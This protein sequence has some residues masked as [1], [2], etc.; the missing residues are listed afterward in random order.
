MRMVLVRLAL[1]FLLLV[2]MTRLSNAQGVSFPELD[3]SV[4]GLEGITYL[5][6]VRQ[7]IP[8]LALNGSA[9]QGHDLIDMR[10]IAGPSDTERPSTISLSNVAA[11]DVASDGKERLLLLVDLG[12]QAASAEGFAVLALYDLAGV[13]KLVDAAN[14]AYDQNTYFRDPGRL[15]LGQGKD[16]VVTISTHFN[17][18]Q[19]YVTTVLILIRNDRLELIDSIFTFDEKL[20]SFTR[21]QE[22]SLRAI[23][24]DGNTY[25]GIE[26]AVNETTALT[27]Q[28][29]EGE[30]TPEPG[31]RTISTTYRWDGERFVAAS[32]ALGKLAEENAERF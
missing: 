2:P 5:E 28:N 32:D 1:A 8:N 26:V 20:C 7:L 27:G 21:T 15:P 23:D 31:I 12:Q 9:Y 30:K 24:R 13:P 14:V 11:L 6:L 18:N 22:P 19:A 3:A 16:A 29:C 10:N 17:S 25:G 4:R